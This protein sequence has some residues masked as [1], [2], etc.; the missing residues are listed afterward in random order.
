MIERVLFVC[1]GNIC[2]SPL[3]E[4]IF[5]KQ[6]AD[7]GLDVACDSAAVAGHHI[8]EAP[9]ARAVVAARISNI[10]IA[11]QVARQVCREDFE[12]FDLV[13]AMDQQNM[14]DLKA[15]CPAELHYKIQPISS[16][17]TDQD[18]SDIADPYYSGRFDPVIA[19]LQSCISGLI[20][21]LQKERQ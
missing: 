13:I 6:A 17:A 15:E 1:L 10:D 8:G 3:A 7:L 20:S 21:T 5:K 16:Y 19:R 12:R 14:A 2:R 9:D 11:N 18:R 4:G